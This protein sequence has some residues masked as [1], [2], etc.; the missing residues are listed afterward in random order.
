VIRKIAPMVKDIHHLHI[1]RYGNHVEL[2]LHIRLPSEMKLKDVHKI[3]DG[4]ESAL[5]EKMGLEATIHVDP[6]GEDR[7]K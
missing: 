3:A 4:I 5:R 7:R 1:H 6:A 2:T